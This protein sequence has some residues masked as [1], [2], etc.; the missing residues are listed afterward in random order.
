MILSPSSLNRFRRYLLLLAT[1]VLSGCAIPGGGARSVARAVAG[2]PVPLTAQAAGPAEVAG[3]VFE[4]HLR[5]DGRDLGVVHAGTAP[6]WEWTPQE[7]GE[8]RARTIVRDPAGKV[9]AESGWSDPYE[10]VPP[11]TVK[12]PTADRPAPQAAGTTI[13]WTTAA[14]GGIGE[15]SYGFELRPEGAAAAAPSVPSPDWLW[16]PAQAG[17]YQ[18][19]AVA[20]DAHGNRA[21]S[22]WSAPYEVVPP[23]AVK[24]PVAD[25]PV[26]QM[27]GSAIRWT[28]QSSG[29]VGEI[30]YEFRLRR[31]E[32]EVATLQSGPAS[33]WLWSPVE[34]GHYL[35]W[36]V[37]E[38]AHGNRAVSEWSAPYEIVPPLKV[39]RL[40]T[41]QPAP[42]TAGTAIRW[43]AAASGGV[44][45]I[46]YGFELW[47]EGAAAA[48]AQ[49]GPASEWLW[50]P[51]EAGRYEARV[52][53]ADSRGTWAEGE[54][55]PP[56]QRLPPLLKVEQLSAG[57][58]APQ[59]AGTAIRW[60]AAAS[61]GVG[62]ITYG[63]ELRREGAVA[64]TA[65]SGPLA[66]WLWSPAEAGRY[67]ARVVAADSRG[68]RAEVSGA[69][70]TR[71]SLR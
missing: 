38:D 1:L 64:A 61:G 2:T 31:A 67:Q 7:P 51:A 68:N 17:R 42:Q 10:V 5:R 36:V 25:R 45:E 69:P 47:R 54:W 50:S 11:L 60:T 62:E 55:A 23:L 43:T 29:G 20:V 53:A 40:S 66:E 35:V 41:G 37:A 52:V 33:E 70:P 26:P 8:Y 30:T 65:Q 15:I 34:A 58:P 46:T 28:V 18:V 32:G 56:V 71:S 49:S 12:T 3:Q 4:F 14:S 6:V 21:E 9:L 39:E 48:A 63:F 27:A 22:D 24:L 59:T 44:G 57:Q 13:R 19:R 16:R